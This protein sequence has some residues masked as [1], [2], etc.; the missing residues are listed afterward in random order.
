[1]S[2]QAHMSTHAYMTTYMYIIYTYVHEAVIDDKS[3]SMRKS[4]VQVCEEF[5]SNILNTGWSFS[6]YAWS[7]GHNLLC[8]KQKIS[9]ISFFMHNETIEKCFTHMRQKYVNLWSVCIKDYFT[10]IYTNKSS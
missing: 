6:E 9:K 1:M 5:L 2:T 4:K 3:H 7:F 8:L 10:E